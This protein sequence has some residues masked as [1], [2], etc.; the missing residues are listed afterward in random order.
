MTEVLFNNIKEFKKCMKTITEE[1]GLLSKRD[2]I[3]H[4]NFNNLDYNEL[5]NYNSIELIGRSKSNNNLYCFM[6]FVNNTSFL[7]KSYKTNSSNNINKVEE[8]IKSLYNLDKNSEIEINL[9]IVLTQLMKINNYI[10]EKK[11]IE[12][13]NIENIQ[14]FTYNNLLFN[15]T[16]HSKVPKHIR[17]IRNKNDIDSLC[18]L[19]NISNIKKL[20]KIQMNDPLANFY[21]LRVGELFEFKKYNKNAGIYIYYRVCV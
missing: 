17:V 6:Y 16:K 2:Y 21:G 4:D 9:I 7:S 19:R 1:E 3:L 15:I 8:E 12:K 10:L 11:I 13:I 18:E 5:N 14:I 20:A